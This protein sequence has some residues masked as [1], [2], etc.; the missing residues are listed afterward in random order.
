MNYYKKSI[1]LGL[2][3]LLILSSCALVSST[4]QKEMKINYTEP[5]TVEFE[6]DS[7][8]LLKEIESDEAFEEIYIQLNYKVAESLPD[9]NPGAAREVNLSQLLLTTDEIEKII[10]TEDGYLVGGLVVLDR[11]ADQPGWYYQPVIT[12]I[13]FQGKILWQKTYNYILYQ[14]SFN[15]LSQLE[16]GEIVVSF[17]GLTK[18]QLTFGRGESSLLLLND[19]GEELWGHC[20]A[21]HLESTLKHILVAQNTIFTVGVEQVKAVPKS[22]HD[23]HRNIIITKINSTGEIV[24]QRSFG[25][26]DYDNIHQVE[27]NQGLGLVLRGVSRSVDGD[28]ALRQEHDS[29]YFVAVLDNSLN[30]KWIHINQ[31]EDAYYRQLVATADYIC[32]ISD[33]TKTDVSSGTAVMERLSPK[34]KVVHTSKN[35][36]EQGYCHSHLV[37]ANGD[38]VLGCG[39][40]NQGLLIV[41]NDRGVEKQRIVDLQYI[42]NQIYPTDDGGYFI[43]STR[44]LKT[45]PQPIWVSSIWFDTEVIVEKYNR[46]HQLEWRK[47]YDSYPDDIGTDFVKPMA[48]G[49]VL[50]E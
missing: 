13:N 27:Y 10:E 5:E 20:F 18:C 50:I 17:S 43:K 2:M 30:L 31:I 39:N 45:I 48:S 44:T 9:Y 16:S 37:L 25:G 7:D 24:A 11:G 47:S 33:L 22:G 3:L 15:Y 38:A 29:R 28:F 19:D 12:K 34:G 35:F 23:D 36:I 49:Q 42:P 8:D 46:D 32:L 40:D 6:K 14:G 21:D 41:L 1:L 26:T 4:A